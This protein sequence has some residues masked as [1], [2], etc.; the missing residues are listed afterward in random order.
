MGMSYSQKL[1]LQRGHA[2]FSNTDTGIGIP[3]G[4]GVFEIFRTTK[5]DARV[6]ACLWSAK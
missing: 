6:E 3:E 2:G 4:M 1:S 5:S